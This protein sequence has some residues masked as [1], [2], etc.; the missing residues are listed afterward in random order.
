MYLGL[1]N[2]Y[3][4]SL[5]LALA[6]KNFLVLLSIVQVVELTKLKV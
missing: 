6:H 3:I 5:G 1:F 4:L 2:H